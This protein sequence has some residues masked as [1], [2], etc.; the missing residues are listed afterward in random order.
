MLYPVAPG[1]A[2]HVNVMLSVP[3]AVAVT[4]VGGEIVRA[5][6]SSTVSDESGVCG[7]APMSDNAF[8]VACWIRVSTSEPLLAGV[9]ERPQSLWFVPVAKTTAPLGAT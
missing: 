6:G 4:P 9:R 2:F 5:F 8:A 3:A 1:N 7:S